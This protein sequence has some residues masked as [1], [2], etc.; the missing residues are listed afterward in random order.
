MTT[1]RIMKLEENKNAVM[2]RAACDCT[3]QDCDMTLDLEVDEDF[4]YLTLFKKLR[5]SSCWKCENIFQEIW[6]R[7]SC[8]VKVLFTGYIEVEEAFLMRDKQIDDFVDA[9]TEAKEK[10]QK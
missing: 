8:A 5:W 9:I 1:N 3:D 7:I 6:L 4:L 10:L 2:F